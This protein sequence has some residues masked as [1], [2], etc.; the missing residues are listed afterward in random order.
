MEFINR[1]LTI[2][3]EILAKY[4]ALDALDIITLIKESLAKLFA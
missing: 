1:L 3:Q 4:N 2:A